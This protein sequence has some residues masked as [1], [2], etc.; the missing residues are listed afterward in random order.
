MFLEGLMAGLQTDEWSNPVILNLGVLGG[1]TGGTWEAFNYLL[2]ESVCHFSH[3]KGLLFL[4]FSSFYRL[5]LQSDRISL[6]QTTC[7]LFKHDV[8][9]CYFIAMFRPSMFYTGGMRRSFRIC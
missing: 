7:Q 6:S 3:I 5:Q 4:L 1:I 2:L 8:I 9:F